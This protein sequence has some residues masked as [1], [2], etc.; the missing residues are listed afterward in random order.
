M[1]LAAT[2]AAMGQETHARESYARAKEI[3]PTMSIA[4]YEKGTRMAWRDRDE[5][6]DA[7]IGPLRTLGVD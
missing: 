5:I 7:V 6:I 3:V 1:S 2:Q 4:L